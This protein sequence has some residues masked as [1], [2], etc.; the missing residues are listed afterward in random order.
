MEIQGKRRFYQ[1][2]RFRLLLISL[3]LLLALP[4]FGY[5]YLQEMEG[6]LRH[7]QEQQLLARAEMAAQLLRAAAAP[8]LRESNRAAQQR[9]AN[10]LYAHPLA[11]PPQLDGYGEEWHPLWGQRRHFHA[12]ASNPRAI[13]FDLLLG[14]HQEWLYLFIE[15]DDPQRV[16]AQAEDRPTAGDHLLLAL[17]GPRGRTRQFVVGGVAPGWVDARRLDDNTRETAIRGEWQETERGYSLELRLPRQLAAGHLSIALVDIDRPGGQPVGRASSSGLDYNRNLSFIVYPSS[18]LAQ[19]LAR[20]GRNHTRFLIIDRQRLVIGQGGEIGPASPRRPGGLLD[21][22]L[23]WL[24]PE[25][26]QGFADRRETLGRLDGPEIRQ[27]LRGRPAV[28]RH[29]GDASGQTRVSAAYPIG[30]EQ[31]PLGALVVEQGSEQILLLQETALERLLRS[32]LLLFLLTLAALL[33]FTTRLTGRIARLSRR[34]NAAISQDG[35]IIGEIESAGVTDE[36][37]ELERR[38]ASVMQR[39]RGYNHYLEAMGS[40]LAHE[41]RTPLAMVGSSLENLAGATDGKGRGRYLERAREGTRRLSRILEQM[42]EATRLEQTLQQAELET[43]DLQRVLENLS[44]GYR[45]TYPECQIH[46]R[47]CADPCQ[48]RVAP[49]LLIQAIDKLLGNAIDFH[50]PDSPIQLLLNRPGPG[51]AR[52]QVINQGPPLPA[53][54]R[55]EL[56]QSMVSIRTRPDSQ[57]H[58]GLGLYLVRL[59]AE[60]HQGRIEAD[61]TRE[62]VCFS[63]WLPLAPV[64]DNLTK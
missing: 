32:S 24:L 18:A 2:L 44:E 27:A 59:I 3:L 9:L 56:F 29:R 40:R 51:M 55:Q 6:L 11:A 12:S 41:F 62:G 4:W 60:F 15:V 14:F 37:G 35:R 1:G 25:T 49:D 46:Y 47:G 16:Y 28:Y 61:N 26:G 38:F 54:R 5:R 64:A 23:G 8:R 39:L 63:L 43:V 20:L 22:L 33:L 21:R 42:R 53:G 30:A 36:I 31:D 57:P 34:I 45:T 48:A 7:S 50:Q 58:L 10:A 52:L 17:P 13:A 19:R